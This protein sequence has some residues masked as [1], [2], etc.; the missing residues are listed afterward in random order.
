MLTV[1]PPLPPSLRPRDWQGSCPG[2]VKRVVTLRKSL[3]PH[4]SRASLEK[5]SLK[6]SASPFSPF[7][8]FLARSPSPSPSFLAL[9][10]PCTLLTTA[11]VSTASKF[12][13]GRFQTIEEKNAFLGPRKI[14]A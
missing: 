6:W 10:L 12:G 14:K 5:V 2:V 4:T 11:I 1:P 13:H 8:A 9:T 7:S 3:V